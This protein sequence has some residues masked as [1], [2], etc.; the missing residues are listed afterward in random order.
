MEYVKDGA[1]IVSRDWGLRNWRKNRAFN[2][3]VIDGYLQDRR[4]Q[5]PDLDLLQCSR[6]KATLEKAATI[7][8]QER[9]HEALIYP[10]SKEVCWS[11]DTLTE[12]STIIQEPSE[13]SFNEF[14]EELRNA[15]EISGPIRA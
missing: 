12:N 7:S 3:G 2:K 5:Y 15:A 6:L 4:T 14:L 10:S 11:S 1:C 9:V 13:F 8:A